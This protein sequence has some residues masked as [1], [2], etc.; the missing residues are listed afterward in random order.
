MSSVPPPECVTTHGVLAGQVVTPWGD[1]Q[2]IR[3][4]EQALQL[5][6]K[7]ALSNISLNDGTSLD[8][9]QRLQNTNFR[10]WFKFDREITYGPS[11]EFENKPGWK[12][13]FSI[14]NAEHPAIRHVIEN[15]PDL[16]DGF[17]VFCDA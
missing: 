14:D 11:G 13:Y 16:I 1:D 10:T 3:L 17:E 4:A 15:L 7:T 12:L 5:R 2:K 6:L 9:Q 8:V